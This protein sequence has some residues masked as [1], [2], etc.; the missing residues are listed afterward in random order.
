MAVTV[1][2][3]VALS[4]NAGDQLYVFEVPAA[5]SVTGPHWLFGVTVIVGLG[6]TVTVTVPLGTVHVPKAP[7]TV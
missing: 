1:A 5:V 7:V 4:P 3:V 2:P 6:L